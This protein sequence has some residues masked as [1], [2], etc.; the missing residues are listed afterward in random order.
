[1]YLFLAGKVGKRSE[2]LCKNT[3]ATGLVFVKEGKKEGGKG[4]RK[5]EG[6]E[7]RKEAMCTH[8]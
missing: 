8:V 3:R 7:G 4:G 5:E 1:M 2:C 6:K